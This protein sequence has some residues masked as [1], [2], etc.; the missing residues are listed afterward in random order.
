MEYRFENP[1]ALWGLL[2]ILPYLAYCFWKRKHLKDSFLWRSTLLNSIALSCC[3]IGLARPQGGEEISTQISQ[4]ANLF[5][6][7]DI[8]Q[9]MLAEDTLPSRMRFA[10]DFSKTLLDQ[11]S[12]VKVALFPFALDGYMQMPLSADIQA[13]KDLLTAMSP[14]IATGQGTDLG[15]TLTNLLSQ[16]Q[17]SEK[18]AKSRGNDWVTPQ[19]LLISDGESHVPVDD[20]VASG[21]KKASIPIFTVCTG[22]KKEVPIYTENRFGLK[23]V[24]RDE[25]GKMALTAAHPEVLSRIA[26]IS[27]GFS[28]QDSFTEVP[29]IVS[30]LK[31]SLQIGKLST[32]FKLE[33]EFY[34]LCFLIGFICLF[35]EFC[36]GKWELAIRS[37]L[38]GFVLSQSVFGSEPIENESQAIESY[39]S[40]VIAYENQNFKEAASQ[41][42]KSILTSL[43]PTVRKKALFNLGNVYLKMGDT[44]QALDAYQHS[45][46]TEAPNESFNKE[47]NQKISDNLDLLERL[48]QQ[49]S[50]QR[51]K[52]EK[53]GDGDGEGKKSGKGIDPKGPK[54]FEDES[55]S[56]KMKQKVF[57]QISDEERETLKKLAEEKNRKSNFR[58]LKPW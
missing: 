57:D 2:I 49:K 58:N 28:F 25:S 29:K 47:T 27:G 23:N 12:Q 43:D 16:I 45:H 22:G 52:E 15:A 26:D 19:V 5:I 42:E 13:A 54:S 21:Y 1:V 31:Q 6:A 9:S 10:I 3:L 36:F 44:E 55:L 37:L 50:K 34:P 38:I 56:E 33:H 46:D 35:W 18:I 48:K 4:Q 51:S 41:F 14:S 32:T 53:E 40:G 7:I 24:L 20:S 39:N 8:S 30:R 11:I 17:R